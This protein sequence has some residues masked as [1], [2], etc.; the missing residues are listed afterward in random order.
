METQTDLDKAILYC[1]K[2]C[3]EAILEKRVAYIQVDDL[4]ILIRAAELYAEEKPE[5]IKL[6]EITGLSGIGVD[7]RNAAL[8]VMAEEAQKKSQLILELKKENKELQEKLT[9]KRSIKCQK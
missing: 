3:D 6:R 1:S 9:M 7:R 4:D 8:R 2:M 5:L